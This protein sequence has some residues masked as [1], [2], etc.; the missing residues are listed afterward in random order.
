MDWGDAIDS[1]A[2]A[3]EAR[4][5][6]KR[7]EVGNLTYK[8]KVSVRAS[9]G[10]SFDQVTTVQVIRNGEEDGTIV[11]V[12]RGKL[13]PSTFHNRF[14]PGRGATCEY[15]RFSMAFTVRGSSETYGDYVVFIRPE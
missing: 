12:D 13:K 2:T 15:T 7:D 5:W 8:A 11:L 14:S 1:F 9:R 6:V 10:A 3:T 4:G